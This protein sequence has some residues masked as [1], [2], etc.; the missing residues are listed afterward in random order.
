MI[1]NTKMLE[2]CHA[3]III[4]AF[5]RWASYSVKYG[6]TYGKLLPEAAELINA[7]IAEMPT[8]KP[9]VYYT[10]YVDNHMRFKHLSQRQKTFV[11]ELLHA[12]LT[13]KARG[14]L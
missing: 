1:T 10:W 6:P 13:A 8:L 11:N 7:A 3:E 5:H 2:N 4:A 9:G 14:E 12:F